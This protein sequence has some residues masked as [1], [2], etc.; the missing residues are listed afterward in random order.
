MFCGYLRSL[1]KLLITATILMLAVDGSAQMI[2]PTTSLMR[3]AGNIHQFNKIF[4][5]EKVYLQ[6]DNT[7]Y[8]S[9][10][11]IWFKAFV[12]QASNLHRAASSVL[13]AAQ[14]QDK[15]WTD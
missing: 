14:T 13:Y 5:Q 15:K 1:K 11:T 12:V 8:F 2:E 6:F 3:Y 7:A 9:G 4:P 10:E